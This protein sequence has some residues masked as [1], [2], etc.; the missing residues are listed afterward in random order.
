MLRDRVREGIRE[1]RQSCANCCG[2]RPQIYEA[3]GFLGF[4][5]KKTGEEKR[6]V[7]FRLISSPSALCS[8]YLLAKM[9]ARTT[10]VLLLLE[11]PLF[12]IFFL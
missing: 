4:A 5:A 7:S 10:H 6:N 8:I 9:M 3:G 11:I 2:K 1:P 12:S